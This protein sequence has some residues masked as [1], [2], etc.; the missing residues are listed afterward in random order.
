VQ[1][2]AISDTT[3]GSSIYYTTDGSTPTTS[4]TKYAGAITVSSTETIKAI[5][6]ATSY[7]N[8]AVASAAYT[9]N[10]PPAA[11]PTFSPAAGTYTS[12][13]TVAISDTTAGSSIYYTTDGSTPTTSSTKYAGAITVNSTETLKALATATGDSNSAVASAAYTINLPTVATPIFSPA[14]GTFTSAQSITISDATSGATIYYTTDGS[15]P[16]TNSTKYTAA[17]AVSATETIKAIATATGDSPSGVG[18]ATYTITAPPVTATPTFSPAAGTYTSVQSVTISDTTSGATIYYTTDGTTPTNASTMYTAPIAVSATETI[19]AIATAS[20]YSPSGV[21][22]AAYTINLPVASFTLAASP[23][24]ASIS[25]GQS[26][27]FTLTVTPQNGFTQS[28]TFSCSGLPSGDTCSFSPATVTPSGAPVTSALTIASA[29]TTA[30]NQ[31]Q[32]LPL[33][34]KITSGVS[35]ALLLWP[36][37]KR[38]V[39][40]AFVLAILFGAGFVM[41]GCGG[42]NSP[43]SKNYTVTV[44]ATGGSV[45]Q[46]TNLALT[47]KN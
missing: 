41:V 37:R 14:S 9:I 26:A 1:T 32:S 31:S 23:S 7:S 47:V 36:I 34:A 44:T 35:M 24:N 3:A 30:M 19:N 2:V 39:W 6:A 15:I 5:A 17:I 29:T 25:S 43:K 11:T 21:A 33:W 8:S 18:S 42:S 38:R 22:T 16:T 27:Q 12:V 13:Q 40:A 10:L 45:T 46:T 4:S 20:G 28:V